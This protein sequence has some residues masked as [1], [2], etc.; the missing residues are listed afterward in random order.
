MFGV[1]AGKL[2]ERGVG[3]ATTS[4]RTLSSQRFGD[5]GGVAFIPFL[6]GSGIA[7]DAATTQRIEIGT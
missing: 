1:A 3:R 4:P 5:E 6:F 7:L 2:Q